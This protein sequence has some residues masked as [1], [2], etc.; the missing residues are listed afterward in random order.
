MFQPR[1]ISLDNGAGVPTDRTRGERFHIK[2]SGG[3]FFPTTAPGLLVQFDDDGTF[4][5]VLAGRYFDR[6]FSSITL[7]HPKALGSFNIV[8]YE[9]NEG[10]R[11]MPQFLAQPPISVVMA[12]SLQ[13]PTA[14]TITHWIIANPVGSGKTYVLEHIQTIQGSVSAATSDDWAVGTLAQLAALGVNSVTNAIL[15]TTM[16]D[17]AGLALL[18]KP[19]VELW[20]AQPA[21]LLITIEGQFIRG[22]E[23]STALTVHDY[24]RGARIAPGN[25]L[26]WVPNTG[27]SSALRTRL[28]EQ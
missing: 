1:T 10:L 27:S 11:D 4:I 28:L 20:L 17:D 21:A 22:R 19:P 25:F 2:A 9:E 23:A 5:P 26:A 15:Q 13:F 8:T 18:G 7:A 16:Y 6:A 24:M 14:A 3:I 12:F